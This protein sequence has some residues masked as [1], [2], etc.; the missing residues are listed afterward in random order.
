MRFLKFVKDLSLDYSFFIEHHGL[1][2]PP[3][4]L[5]Q[6]PV[7]SKVVSSSLLFSF[8]LKKYLHQI[9]MGTV[10]PN[11]NLPDLP[12]RETFNGTRRALR[13]LST[14]DEILLW[15]A[16]TAQISNNIVQLLDIPC[17]V[18][19]PFLSYL[20]TI[21][22]NN[23]DFLDSHWFKYLDL[24]VLAGYPI[25]K[26]RELSDDPVLW[27]SSP[28]E[29]KYTGSWWFERFKTTFYQN[30]ILR[31]NILSYRDYILS[32]WLWVTDGAT[33]YSEA[34]LDDELVRTKFGAAISL[35]ND[36]LLEHAYLNHESAFKIGVFLKPDEPGYKRRLIANVTLGAYLLASYI[37]YYLE[38][39]IQNKPQFLALDLTILDKVDVLELI[40]NGQT[41]VPLDESA[42]DY[43]V[44]SESWAGFQAFLLDLDVNNEA[45]HLFAQ[46][47]DNATWEFEGNTGRWL[48]GMP[49]GLALTSFLNSWMNFIK[50]DHIIPGRLQFAAGDDVL[51]SP[52][53]SGVDLEA[54]ATEYEKFG[55]SVNATKNWVS[56]KY[57]EYLKVLYHTNGTTG[58]PARVYSSLIW[59]GKERSFLPSDKLPELAE[60][61]KQFYDRLGQE[62]DVR[63]VS[64]DLAAA[65]SHKVKGFNAREAEKWLHSPRAYGGFG[66]LPY[67]YFSWDWKTT[68]L[69]KR[70]YTQ[71]II[72]V[73]DVNFYGTEVE[74]VTRKRPLHIK[75]RYET[76]A[77]LRLPTPLTMEDW[78]ARLNGDDIPIKGKFGRMAL[79]I[80]PLPT[81][82]H[83]STATVAEFAEMWGFNVLPNIKGDSSTI[84]DAL[85]LASIALKNRILEF[86]RS[87]KI[88]QFAN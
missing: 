72:K 7:Y 56:Q 77:P 31:T 33:R 87:R 30:T 14:P 81:I 1:E 69:K 44:S 60:L 86:F 19:V 13:F 73:P 39:S 46:Y 5:S 45:F 75:R 40:R 63:V 74:L 35:S 84:V 16:K 32:R 66:L 59:A 37:R 88:R 49:S 27:L 80:I 41:M 53:F 82:N 25:M 78:E 8:L 64:K 2:E 21:F 36:T 58:Y 51:T 18:V 6:I 48:S 22:H 61:F 28:V 29:S 26:H 47:K 43:H 34:L 4:D 15:Y 67:S 70:K 54:V 52:F 76:G 68:I 85:V 50:Q 17:N 23:C 20:K 10:L 65:V 55:S 38:N 83:V 42:Y 11:S 3:S 79:D 62:L 24:S 12:W 71:V 57:A 9:R